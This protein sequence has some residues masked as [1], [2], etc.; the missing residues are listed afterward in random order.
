MEFSIQQWSSIVTGQIKNLFV[1]VVKVCNTSRK[2]ASHNEEKGI[3]LAEHST[4]KTS[5]IDG[6][7]LLPALT[8]S[9]MQVAGYMDTVDHRNLQVVCV[10]I[11]DI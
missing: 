11:N 3:T 9:D 4:A 1:S 7:S 8:F 6:A 2:Y 5:N 10:E